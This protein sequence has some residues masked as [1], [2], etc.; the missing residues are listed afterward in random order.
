MQHNFPNGSMIRIVG[1]PGTVGASHCRISTAFHWLL[2]HEHS[3][4]WKGAMP[5]QCLTRPILVLTV[6]EHV[7]QARRSF[8]LRM[9]QALLHHLQLLNLPSRLHAFVALENKR[10]LHEILQ[11]RPLRNARVARALRCL[12][13]PG[14]RGEAG[15]PEDATCAVR[16]GMH[17]VV[18][19]GGGAPWVRGLGRLRGEDEGQQRGLGLFASRDGR[20][21]HGGGI[22]GSGCGGARRVREVGGRLV[23][24]SCIHAGGER[25][26]QRVGRPQLLLRMA[27]HRVGG[28]D[29]REG[30]RGGG[31]AGGGDDGGVVHP[32][33][34]G[35][36]VVA[37]ARR[38]GGRGWQAEHGGHGGAARGA[39]QAQPPALG[40][41]NKH[42]D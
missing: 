29:V 16:A 30:V 32:R 13:G 38:R 24:C 17:H 19:S 21:G 31:G 39:G 3:R 41:C 14:A 7:L 10:L 22:R 25:A 33:G 9:V 1:L 42:V 23:R 12:A 35:A 27:E 8:R 40:S 4:I 6:M 11:V 34:A 36:D 5:L 18:G 20:R 28:D 15:G 37:S 2:R 26:V